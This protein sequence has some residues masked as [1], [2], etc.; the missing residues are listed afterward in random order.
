VDENFKYK[1]FVD[2]NISLKSSKLEVS[3]LLRALKKTNKQ[4][5]NASK[6]SSGMALDIFDVMDLRML[7]GMIGEMFCYNLSNICFN[8]KK[9]PNIDGYPDLCDTSSSLGK[10]LFEKNQS[11]EFIDFPYGGLEIKNTFGT[12]SS[13]ILLNHREQ[14]LSKINKRLVWK[15][16]HQRTNYLLALHSDYMRRIPQI[17][18]MFFANNLCEDDWTSKQNPKKGSTMT[19]FT[20]TKTSA[21]EKLKMGKL[22]HIDQLIYSNFLK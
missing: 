2:D 1:N 5:I 16:H 7:S 6:I 21:Y 13:G 22:F 4:L 8:L 10:K 11:N 12:K 14:R 17:I 18:A 20:Q 3:Y 19:S 15:A 9:N